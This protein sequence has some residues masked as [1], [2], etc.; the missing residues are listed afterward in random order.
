MLVDLETGSRSDPA[1]LATQ[2]TVSREKDGGVPWSVSIPAA[3]VLL[4][5]AMFAVSAARDI[6][7]K[8]LETDLEKLVIRERGA[9]SVR[10]LATH[11]DEILRLLDL[12]DVQGDPRLVDAVE[13]LREALDRTKRACV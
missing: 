2:A 6:R 5:A 10:Q 8:S 13:P 3:A 1:R 7:M 12:K 4:A 11:C 9:S